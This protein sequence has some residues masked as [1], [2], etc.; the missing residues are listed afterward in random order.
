MRETELAPDYYWVEG[1]KEKS[2][3]EI[4]GIWAK[5]YVDGEFVMDFARPENLPTK[6]QS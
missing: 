4:R 2:E 1:G 6:A 5:I 3:D